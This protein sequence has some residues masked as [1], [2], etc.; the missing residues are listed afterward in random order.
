MIEIPKL[1]NLRSGQAPRWFNVAVAACMVL[2]ATSSLVTSLRTGATMRE[3]LDQN[4]R[5]VRASS[6]PV[7]EFSSGNLT[8]EGARSINLSVSNVGAGFARIVWF[9]LSLKDGPPL[10]SMR[11]LIVSMEAEDD[12]PD[13]VTRSI[14]PRLFPAGREDE[15]AKWPRPGPQDPLGQRRWDRLNKERFLLKVQACFCSVLQE[16]WLSHLKGGVP[17]PVPQCEPTGK[18]SLEGRG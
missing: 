2:T 16:C 12:E 7:L 3:M 17:Q 18:T 14:A 10:K 5:L 4:Q 1:P 15:I 8:D 11:D 9:E 13:V 6:T